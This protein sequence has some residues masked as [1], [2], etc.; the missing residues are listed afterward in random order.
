MIDRL[1]T[2]FGVV[3]ALLLFSSTGSAKK[4]KRW[5]YPRPQWPVPQHRMDPEPCRMFL[6]NAV[7]AERFC[8]CTRLL[9]FTAD[10][11][12]WE[13]SHQQLW[14]RIPFTSPLLRLFP[15]QQHSLTRCAKCGHDYR[16]H[17]ERTRQR[18]KG[19]PYDQ[20]VKQ[21]QQQSSRRGAA[22]FSKD[23]RGASVFSDKKKKSKPKRRGAAPAASITSA[24]AS[25]SGAGSGS[26]GS[27]GA[28]D[29]DDAAESFVGWRR[30][31]AVL[32]EAQRATLLQLSGHHVTSAQARAGFKAQHDRRVQ[33]E[34]AEEKR[35]RRNR[36]SSS[37]S[38]SIE[39]W[40][41]G[42]K[43]YGSNR[44]LGGDR[45]QRRRGRR[46][47]DGGGGGGGGSSGGVGVANGS[48]VS[49][50]GGDGRGRSSRGRGYTE[51]ET[52]QRNLRA[53]DPM[54]YIQ[55]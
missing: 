17:V 34:A 6:W 19:R 47:G 18:R 29:D 10:R 1:K 38:S 40:V 22:V 27:S 3:V 8:E 42:R 35:R 4:A 32:A 20:H 43:D 41:V 24:I 12:L 51:D 33:A 39:R 15:C 52:A 53:F 36:S 45:R 11:T 7:S 25:A 54:E 16:A 37:S 21:Q 26:Y 5:T 2:A 31:L 9:K 28:D 50:R 49:S 13:D 46:A 55:I 44:R 30:R 14:L 48:G 23:Y